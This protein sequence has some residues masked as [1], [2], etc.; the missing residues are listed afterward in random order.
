MTRVDTFKMPG[1]AIGLCALFTME[2]VVIVVAFQLLT[3]VECRLTV[4]EGA[5]RGLRGTVIRALCV[6][7]MLGIYLW[8][9][10]GA[11]GRFAEMVAAG[12]GGSGWIA[13][14]ALG[15]GV[16]LA[17]LAVV[18]PSQMNAAFH[19]VFPVLVVGALL[20]ML[21][22]VFWLARPGAWARWLSGR[23]GEM[24]ALAALAM[25][26]PDLAD[27]LAPLWYWD[28]LT[29]ITFGAV[30]VSLSGLAE[31]LVVRPETHVIGANGFLVA[32]AD[33]C[34]GIEGF[35]LITVFLALYAVLFRDTLRM[36]RFWLVVLPVALL[37]SWVLNVVRITALILIGAHVSP[38]LAVNGFHSFAGW[39][40]FAALSI[41][42]LI[43]VNRSR[44][45][46]VG[47]ASNDHLRLA[48]DDLAARIIPFIVL[49]LSGVI[50]QAFWRAP[51]LGYPLQVVLMAA[52]LWWMRKPLAASL[53][54]PAM[55]AVA[56]GLVIGVVWVVLAE[57]A[58]EPSAA[59]LELSGAAFLIW[60]A[61]RILGTI[62]L[63]PLIEEMFFRGYVQARLDQGTPVSRVVAV[64]VSATL[65][66]LMH[67]R[68]LEAGLAGVVFSL[69]YMRSG[70][71]ADAIAA[72]AVANAL[73]AAVAAW[74]GDWTLI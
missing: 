32:V 63:V 65:F 70:R 6:G 13:L 66:A 68:W 53:C 47:T 35:V 33:S 20:A 34:S 36:G 19:V 12:G 4:I 18:A 48:E 43:V 56:A 15:F 24:A 55:A 62:A 30:A 38:D 37:L 39:L 5:C 50:V 7:I 25:I 60:A 59:L 22:G 49:A 8:A 44:W 40:F 42:I 9:R 11:R 72:H 52:A 41:G 73:I 74:R 28:A 58:P 10:S 57:P 26:L 14:H 69:L 45:L 29:R 21:G 64:A 1:R 2:L 23:I 46:T 17:P 51:E 54:R 16:I 71:I 61:F 27:L 31:T 3:S 67:G